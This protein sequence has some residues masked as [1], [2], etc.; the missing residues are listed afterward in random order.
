MRLQL[1]LPHPD[2]VAMFPAPPGVPQLTIIPT[3]GFTTPVK[4]QVAEVAPAIRLAD[5]SEFR[6]WRGKWTPLPQDSSTAGRG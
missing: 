1:E 2:T 6:S 3:S 5:T 4:L